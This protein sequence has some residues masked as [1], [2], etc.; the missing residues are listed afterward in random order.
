MK[1]LALIPARGGSKGIPNKNLLRLGG[2]SLVAIAGEC[3]K[4]S[5]MFSRIVCSTDSKAIAESAGCEVL[6]RPP[7]LATDE[8]PMLG[9][10]R[11]A[12]DA[13]PCDAVMILQPTSPLRTPEQ[14]QE[15][16]QLFRGGA[17][18]VVSVSPVPKRFAPDYVM[19]L[20]GDGRLINY[21]IRGKSLSRRQDAAEVYERNGTLYLVRC[22]VVRS[23]SLYGHKSIPLVLS[24]EE[25]LTID[26]ERDWAECQRRF[27]GYAA[28]ACEECG[29]RLR[30]YSSRQKG[31]L[32]Q[33]YVECVGCGHRPAA[34]YVP[35]SAILQTT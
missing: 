1:I 22:D 33:R 10:V 9:V 29:G 12:I 26:D 17:H 5:G 14:I 20:D 30:V 21:T 34:R 16:V 28:N 11:H 13:I 8:A 27:A 7:G 32:Q 24:A 23:G 3:A 31:T 2:K 18:S 25:S 35:R 6:D 19:R 4:A 15:A